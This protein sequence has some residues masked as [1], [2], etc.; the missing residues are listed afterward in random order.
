MF[1]KI[2]FFDSFEEVKKKIKDG[3]YILIV[4]EKTEFEVGL[5]PQEIT[6]FGAIFPRII[7]D[8]KSYDKGFLLVPMLESTTAFICEDMSDEINIVNLEK[9]TTLMLLVDGLSPRISSFLENIFEFVNEDAK[10]IGGGAGK[11][12]LEQEPV[13]FSNK[14]I[15]QNAALIIGSYETIGVGVRH[16]WKE[17]KGPFIATQ[18]D[19]CQLEEINYMD[20]FEVYKNVVEKDSGKTFSSENFF[21]IAKSYPFGISRHS[22]ENVVR[23]PILTNGK[24]ITLVG[25][26]DNNSVIHILKG[27]NSNLLKAAKE[28]AEEASKNLSKSEETQTLIIDCIS[29]FLFLE[30]DFDK[31]L[32]NINSIAKKDVLSWGILTLGEIANANQENIE[33]YNKTCVVGKI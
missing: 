30:D 3:K 25:E 17:I 8:N 6:I 28:A 18:T 15:Y 21:D 33:F 32:S 29:R 19:K 2:L 1:K 4:A 11:L 10:I 26:M 7:F 13:I 9:F 22:K 16:G 31:E 14:H 20:A 5:L 27:T 24:S 23:D 12:T